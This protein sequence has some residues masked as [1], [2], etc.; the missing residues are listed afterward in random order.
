MIKRIK[1]VLKHSS[2]CALLSLSGV[3]G[4]G[5]SLSALSL[6]NQ[7][8]ANTGIA[9]P[10]GSEFTADAEKFNAFVQALKAEALGKGYDKDLVETAF[11]DIKFK[12]KV[13][14][15]DRGQ[16]EF[17]ETLE[18]YLPK[19]VT[20][21]TVDKARNMYKQHKTLLDEI[22]EE[23]GVQP[24][25]IVA[26]WGLESAFGK[27]Q[28]NMPLVSSLVTLSYD[29][30]RGAFFKK[31]LWHALD[32]VQKGEASIE[33]LKGSW[34][35]AI[36]QVQFMPSSFK[37]YAVDYDGDG[38]KDV[39][40]NQAD[41][42]ASA[43]NYLKS[44]GWNNNLTWG[45][46]VKLPQGFDFNQAVPTK[47]KGRSDWLKK[48]HATE[49]SLADWQALGV[50]KMDGSNLPTRDIKA[51]ML[52]PDGKNG[53]AYLAYDNYKVLMHWNRSYYFVTTVGYL[54]DRIGY[55]AIK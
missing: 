33:Q 3:V 39:W 5:L 14:K 2:N 17:V 54:A 25:F 55:P 27:Y 4:F 32:I 45:R 28:G 11:Q 10:S 15:A 12:P 9:S 30:R 46:Q 48:W 52:L 50:R 24:R 40:K 47:T 41:V 43:A 19:R 21:W 6:P 44:V 26:L 7:A 49:R 23:F 29:G 31:E 53:R 35:G 36:G 34:A 8:I 20:Q 16:P 51:A 37:A 22:G 42:F 1:S 38:I 18:T 13:I